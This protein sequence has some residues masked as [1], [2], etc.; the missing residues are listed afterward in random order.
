MGAFR[1]TDPRLGATAMLNRGARRH[2]YQ[3]V[4]V[5]NSPLRQVDPRVKLALGLCA[6]L[7]VMLPLERLVIFMFVYALFLSLMRLLPTVALQIWRMR[8]LLIV[9]FVVDLWLVDL[10]LAVAVTLRLTLLAGVFSLLTATTTPRE[11]SLA[12]ENLHLPYRYAFSLGLAFQ[13]LSLLD[14]EWRMIE[15]AQ[16]AR[17]IWPVGKNLRQITNQLRNLVAFTVPAIVLTTKRAWM[18]TEAA[19]ARGFDSPN[20]RPFRTLSLRLRDWL[21]LGGAILILGLLYGV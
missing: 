10:E 8:W 18:I 15:E 9:L 5:E 2:T 4:L 13:S 3:P 6:S 14:E 7:T 17:G 1:A 12:L 11:L 19:Y 16:R 21:F 20:R